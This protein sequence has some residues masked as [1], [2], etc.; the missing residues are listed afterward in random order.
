MISRVW[1]PFLVKLREAVVSLVATGANRNEANVGLE[2]RRWRRRLLGCRVPRERGGGQ[3]A[4]TYDGAFFFWRREWP[5]VC[6][7]EKT[8]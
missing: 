3:E 8:L 7:C 2:R 5:I 4:G 1:Q 6:Y